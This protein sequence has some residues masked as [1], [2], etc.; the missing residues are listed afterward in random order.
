MRL[1]VVSAVTVTDDSF[2]QAASGG[3]YTSIPSGTTGTI[4]NFYS[5]WASYL[6]LGYGFLHAIF[7]FLQGALVKGIFNVDKGLESIYDSVFSLL[8]WEGNVS[9]ASSPLHALWVFFQA[10]GWSILALGAAIVAFESMTHRTNWTQVGTSIVIAGIAMAVLPTLMT[11]FAS[12]AKSAE[13]DINNIST[14]EMASDVAVQ[15]VKNNVIDL[16]TLIRHNFNNFT[17]KPDSK[18]IKNVADWNVI[19]TGR[20]V[21]KMDFGQY[22]DKTTMNDDLKLGKYKAGMAAM[23]YHLED[24]HNQTDGGYIIAK[25]AGA[26]MGTLNDRY[27]SRYSVNWVGLIG[28][29]TVLGIVLLIAGIRVVKDTF[30]LVLMDFVAPLIAYRSIRSTKKIRDLISSIAGMYTSIV[31]MMTIIRVYLISL[32]VCQAKVPAMNWFQRSIVILMIYAG[33]AFAMFAGLNYLERVTGVSQGLSDEAGQAIA[34][35]AAAG[36]VGGVTAGLMGKTL[37]MAG[38]ATSRFGARNAATSVGNNRSNSS[39]LGGL[40]TNTGQSNSR[41]NGISSNIGNSNS[42]SNNQG[43]N[44]DSK[45]SQSQNNGLSYQNSDQEANNQGINQVEGGSNSQNSNTIPGTNNTQANSGNHSVS[46]NTNNTGT[47]NVNDASGAGNVANNGISDPTL[48]TGSNNATNMSN[49]MSS[50]GMNGGQFYNTNSGNVNAGSDANDDPNF[51]GLSEPNMNSNQDSEA[52]LGYDQNG[53]DDPNTPG[54]NSDNNADSAAP[55]GDMIDDNPQSGIASDQDGYD[56]QNGSADMN[57][58]DNM[59]ANMPPTSGID[60]DNLNQDSFDESNTPGINSDNNSTMPAS[61]AIDGNPQTRMDSAMNSSTNM[62][63]GNDL[64]SME[65]NM[66]TDNSFEGQADR[67]NDMGNNYAP[68]TRTDTTYQD[69]QFSNDPQSREP[70]SHDPFTSSSTHYADSVGTED[71]RPT[72]RQIGNRVTNAGRHVSNASRSIRQHSTQYLKNHQFNLSQNG[73]LQGRET[74]RLDD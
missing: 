74:D 8:G 21:K 32:N 17:Y 40:S 51:S 37:Q 16:S 9:S 20:D 59:E 47:A 57:D 25:N 73:N 36:A 54:I 18:K 48:Q 68:D 64:S 63:N 30:E 24:E 3:P 33:G 55:A 66:P 12:V 61:D 53:F 41:M 58:L 23:N 29:A 44:N 60:N 52:D 50:A 34:T 38:K 43:L 45:T 26:G 6:H 42:Q 70:Q 15:P 1:S 10:F 69:S 28:Q 71:N 13:A 67:I 39:I 5:N 46:T 7:G 62:N 56:Y 11:M 49:D 4:I 19:H 31:F 2:N 22:L 65:A 72:A 35:G 14:P 27:Y